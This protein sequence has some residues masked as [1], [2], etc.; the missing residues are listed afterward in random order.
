[1][2]PSILEQ[3]LEKNHEL[4]ICPDGTVLFR[5]ARITGRLSF[6]Q[7]ADT[8]L[9][10]PP[11][12]RN[13]INEAYRKVSCS[14]SLKALVTP[15]NVL[16][17]QLAGM[18][19]AVKLRGDDFVAWSGDILDTYQPENSS[20]VLELCRE[21]GL[22]YYFQMGNHDW[23]Y[24][25]WLPGE[26]AEPSAMLPAAMYD[27][28][29]RTRQAEEV[30]TKSWSMPGRYYS[31]DLKGVRFINTDPIHRTITDPSIGPIKLVST[32]DAPQANW[33]TSQLRWEGPMII[34]QHVPFSPLT[35][36]YQAEPWRSF[37]GGCVSK[38]DPVSRRVQTAV[39]NCPNLLG[40]FVGH[41]H[42]RTEDPLGNTWQFMT[43]LPAEGQSRHVII[44]N[45]PFPESMC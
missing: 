33:L 11:D 40:V 29:L 16:K 7:I 9:Y 39:E 2:K 31:F 5:D 15:Y 44:S 35:S 42:M 27:I 6:T 43:G 23:D 1:M 20:M 22:A 10:P 24:G 25:W 34:F 32:Y 18:L 38:E 19:D 26:H 36:E 30:M 12:D 17:K 14:G 3:R 28:G 45:E 37:A 21:R 13:S 4:R 8:H 41:K